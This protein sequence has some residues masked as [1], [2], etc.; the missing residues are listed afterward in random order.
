MTPHIDYEDLKRFT[1][2]RPDKYGYWF[3]FIATYPSDTYACCNEV[4]D[5]GQA[6]LFIDGAFYH[7]DRTKSCFHQLLVKRNEVE[8]LSNPPSL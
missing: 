1:R 3:R 6:F 4:E 7:C 5:R 2:L 8:Q